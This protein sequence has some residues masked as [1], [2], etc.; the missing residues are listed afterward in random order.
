[1]T[2]KHATALQPVLAAIDISKLLHEVLIEVPR[3]KRRRRATV[4]GCPL[5][6]QQAI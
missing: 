3:M 4:T 5:N 1:M 6:R 2:D